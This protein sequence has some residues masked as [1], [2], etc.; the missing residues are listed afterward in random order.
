MPWQEA[1]PSDE[2]EEGDVIRT[3]YC[4]AAPQI[5]YNDIYAQIV[6]SAGELTGRLNQELPEC[7]DAEV[8]NTEL[9][10]T[11]SNDPPVVNGKTCDFTYVVE[12]E[13]TRK[14]QGC[15]VTGELYASWIHVAIAAIAILLGIS[16]VFHK[17]TQLFKEAPESANRLTWAAVLAAGGYLISKG[18]DAFGDDEPA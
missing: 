15:E 11:D 1:D 16:L 12:S 2:L 17:M 8:R 5:P 13:I 14:E 18:D 10:E 9:I 4:V 6:V 3:H 7:T